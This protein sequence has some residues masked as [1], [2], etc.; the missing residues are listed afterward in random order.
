[1]A[2]N[3]NTAGRHLNLMAYRNASHKSSIHETQLETIRSPARGF[4][5]TALFGPL[6]DTAFINLCDI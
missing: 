6:E 3:M 5:D 2:G 4:Q 1:M